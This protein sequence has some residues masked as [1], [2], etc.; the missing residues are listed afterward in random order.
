MKKILYPIACALC[1]M[2]LGISLSSCSDDAWGNDN[3]ETE[4]V[5]YFG[6]EDWGRLNNGVTYTVAQGQT[7]EIPVQFWCSGTRSFDAESSYRIGRGYQKDLRK[8]CDLFVA[9]YIGD[10]ISDPINSHSC[11]LWRI[12]ISFHGKN[13][14]I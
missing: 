4:N 14:G 2:I 3:S 7:V 10:N 8:V 12:Q 11:R 1:T 6:F 5:F 13:A 9:P